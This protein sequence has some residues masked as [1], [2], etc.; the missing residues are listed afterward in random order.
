MNHLAGEY[1]TFV[2]GARRE[3]LAELACHEGPRYLARCDELARAL[4]LLFELGA[5][6]DALGDW[7]LVEAGRFRMLTREEVTSAELGEAF[8]HAIFDTFNQEL[9]ER[10]FDDDRVVKRLNRRD[11]ARFAGGQDS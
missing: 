2:A 4:W 11:R 10:G 7:Y 6:R 1:Q 3:L 5:K 8:L 9:A